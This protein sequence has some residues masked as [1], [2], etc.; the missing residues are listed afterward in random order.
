MKNSIYNS[1]AII[2]GR[3]L[4]RVSWVNTQGFE[5]TLQKF[6][7]FCSNVH[8]KTFSL[9]YTTPGHHCFQTFP[10]WEYFGNEWLIINPMEFVQKCRHIKVC[11]FWMEDKSWTSF[12]SLK[13]L[14]SPISFPLLQPLYRHWLM[15]LTHHYSMIWLRGVGICP[16][17]LFHR[18][19]LPLYHNNSVLNGI[20]WLS[21]HSPL[22]NKNKRHNLM[23]PVPVS[24]ECFW[25]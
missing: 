13:Y 11:Q 6:L 9:W 8:S 14:L 18:C 7:V 2:L 1:L 19:W 21:L 20:K 25:W 12:Y 24:V 10:E 23:P 22:S 4:Y 15:T 17:T 5:T 16:N 3:R